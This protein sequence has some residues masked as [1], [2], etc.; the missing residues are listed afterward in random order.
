MD[1]KRTADLRILHVN[2]G[3]P[4]F[5]GG[6]Q[7]FLQQVARRQAQSGHFVQVWTTDVGEIEHLWRRDKTV[8]PVGRETDHGVEIRRFAIEHLPLLPYSYHGL[9]RLVV[10]ASRLSIIPIGILWRLA[11]Y[12]PWVPAL[13]R[14]LRQ[15]PADVDLVHGWNIPFESLLAPAWRYAQR[16]N[17]P[18]VATPL[19]HL[20]EA[21]EG[22]QV[23][24]YYTMRHQMDLLR[25]SD[26]VIALTALEADFLKAGGVSAERVHII[27]GGADLD[28]LAQGDA[29]RFRRWHGI[30]A[31][32]VLFIGALNEQKGV[33][34]LLEAMRQLWA[35]GSLAELV[36]IG[37]P[38]ERFRRYYA[39]L[40][41]DEANRCH[42]LGAVSE[43]VKAD[44]LAACAMLT[45]PSRTE[46]FGL[47]FVEAWSVAKP[48]IG[49]RAGAIP[50]VIDEGV[51]GLLVPFGNVEALA[52][53]IQRLLDSPAL[54]ARM[55]AAG[56]RKVRAHHS[57]DQVATQLEAVYDQVGE[58]HG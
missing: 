32:F 52:G 40:S 53:A 38:M 55:G 20:G 1:I 9:R 3:Y 49:A 45:L 34:V 27:G 5:I 31:P 48:V 15:R 43:A 24:R 14:T 21:T 13:P 56:Q 30:T 58:H 6:A 12:T 7:V 36:L 37:Q 18:F 17:I 2:I 41:P 28:G 11:R 8:L 50:A 4:P 47:V 23:R 26:A 51:N 10:E 25:Q 46:S 57:W 44:G 42:V 33:L 22:Q 54:A 39:A 29:A 19:V 16:H 35:Q